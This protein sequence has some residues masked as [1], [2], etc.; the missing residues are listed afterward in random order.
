[1]VVGTNSDGTLE[2]CRAK[3]ENRGKGRCFHTAHVELPTERA[4]EVISR[5][6]ERI[7]KESLGNFPKTQ[8][9]TDTIPD[10]VTEEN[11]STHLN[12][13][14]L[15]R[16]ELLES[17]QKLSE[18][19]DPSE[20]QFLK[21]FH[22]DLWEKLND[23]GKLHERAEKRIV[24]FLNSD[25]EYAVKTREFL[26]N[27]VDIE[28]FSR[29]LTH[30]VKSMTSSLR[31]ETKRAPIN[32]VILTTL[33]NDM[34]KER[35]FASVMFFGGR[36]CYCNR[37]LKKDPPPS[38][39]ASG[40]HITPISPSKRNSVYGGT[41]FGNMALACMKCNND[42]KNSDLTDWVAKTKCIKTEEK[43]KVLARI[44]AFRR[45]AVYHEYTPEESKTISDSIGKLDKQLKD[46]RKENGGVF[47]KEK[48]NEFRDLLKI[49]IVNL[50]HRL[51]S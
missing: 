20:W 23:A 36:C 3:P 32:R 6:N 47:P 12:G 40:E 13:R 10:D 22:K 39:Q 15:S 1:M 25:D 38:R 17:S 27:E 29:I 44:N 35:Y 11:I 48:E 46:I 7:F 42:R 9:E 8:S 18:N 37:V 19:I 51:Q 43:P 45:F 33:N 30:Q 5:T 24:E 34:S 2:Q 16:D 4:N 41:K 50:Q 21:N 26:G 31:W 14:V 49:E 28:D